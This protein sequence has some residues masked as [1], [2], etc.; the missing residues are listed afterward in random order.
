[1]EQRDFIK[2]EI[3]RLGRVLGKIVADFLGTNSPGLVEH[4]IQISQEQLKGEL[5][6]DVNALLVLD[7]KDLIEYLVNRNLTF[8]HFEQLAL[9]LKEVGLHELDR[10]KRKAKNY[11]VR[12]L[13]LLNAADEIS[14][15]ASFERMELKSSINGLLQHCVDR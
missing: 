6:I 8:G 13:D 7:T 12:S 3:E 9:Y 11:L 5:D 14:R 10:D 1:M 2:D 4:S 15:S